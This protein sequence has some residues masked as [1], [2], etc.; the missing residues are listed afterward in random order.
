MIKRCGF[1]IILLLGMFFL[2]ESYLYAD[3]I[4]K[5]IPKESMTVLILQ[6]RKNDA[7]LDYIK[8]VLKDKLTQEKDASKIQAIEDLFQMFNVDKIASAAFYSAIKPMFLLVI[9]AKEGSL[10]QSITD[11]I[12][13]LFDNAEQIW[14]E[15][16]L[17]YKVLYNPNRYN[18]PDNKDLSC[19]VVI[20]NYIVIANDPTILRKVADTYM[21]K[22]PSIIETQEFIQNWTKSQQDYDVV[23]YITNKNQELT[24][25]LDS[26]KKEMGFILFT[27]SDILR[28]V[29]IYFDL[30]D[31]ENIK[32]KMVF[33]PL[34][35][36]P[37]SRILNDAQYLVEAMRRKFIAEN[38]SYDTK[39][40]IVNKETILNVNIANTSSF[41][42]KL[43]LNKDTEAS[44]DVEIESVSKSSKEK[45]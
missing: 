8:E 24:N 41:L 33:S 21:G 3:E 18:K 7:G 6:N 42:R 23:M 13:I 5:L 40:D 27:S 44:I 10:L 26:W 22:K 2:C 20:G 36:D 4:L 12:D 9:E 45:K 37:Q 43:I 35:D 17:D 16:Y 32:G 29:W 19:Y 34:R 14:Q 1:R 28:S 38:L 25:S 15:K 31:K 30:V 11:K 39:I